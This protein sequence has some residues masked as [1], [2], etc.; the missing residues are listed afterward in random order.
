MS[1]TTRLD[2]DQTG[3][4]PYHRISEASDQWIAIAAHGADEKAAFR[5]VLGSDEAGFVAAA[6]ARTAADLLAA[7]EA[8]GVPCD[9]VTFDD[10][11]NRFFADPINKELALFTCLEHPD[12]GVIEQTGEFW[13]FGEVD[14]RI[15]R[16]CPTIGQHTDEIMREMGFT[17]AEIATYRERKI[18][19]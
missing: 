11:M 10:A 12:Y 13:S 17:D 9:L 14:L 15:E 16:P 8:A 19:G 7:L 18:I 6:R 4:G 2:K 3:F 1:Q 5:S